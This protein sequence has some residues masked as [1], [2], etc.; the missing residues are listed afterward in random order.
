MELNDDI[1]A[2]VK[3]FEVVAKQICLLVTWQITM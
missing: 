2:I 1:T 3:R